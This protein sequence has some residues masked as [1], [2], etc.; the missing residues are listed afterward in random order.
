[1]KKLLLILIII[2][3]GA[4]LGIGLHA[5]KALQKNDQQVLSTQS[6]QTVTQQIKAV[7]AIPK[8]LKI[9]AIGVTTVVESVG[10]DSAGRMDVPKNSDNTAWFDLGYRPGQVGNSVIDGHFDKVDGSPAAFWNIGKLQR[11]DK[12]I[13]TDANGKELTFAVT[14]LVKYPYDN[15]PIKEVFG[16]ASVPMLNLI[17]CHGQWNKNTKNYSERMVVYSQLIN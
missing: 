4:G 1:M 16:D 11:G 6:N 17:T 5:S 13:V 3:L 15:F 2:G 14:R 8:A 12:L 9:P 10:M 7:P